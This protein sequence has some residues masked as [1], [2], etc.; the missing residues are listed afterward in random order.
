MFCVILSPNDDNQEALSPTK[1]PEAH[2]ECKPAWN[3][4]IGSSVQ[5]HRH[6]TLLA[7]Y[8]C[9]PTETIEHQS[10]VSF[11]PKIP[12]RQKGTNNRHGHLAGLQHGL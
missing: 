3:R 10:P 1:T 5:I 12:R 2:K 7:E 11:P 8:S 9:R 6:E 4:E